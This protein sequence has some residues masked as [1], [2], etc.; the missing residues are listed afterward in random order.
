M[1]IDS[2]NIRL[3]T[4]NPDGSAEL[5]FADQSFSNIPK[6]KVDLKLQSPKA[7][8]KEYE[9]DPWKIS[10]DR[11]PQ[12]QVNIDRLIGHMKGEIQRMDD[13]LKDPKETLYEEHPHLLQ[14]VADN[15]DAYEG[16]LSMIQANSFK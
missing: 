1:Y 11:N 7:V 16:L 5:L 6:A 12:I 10:F 2:S 4:V 8:S 13:L 3:I 15:K 9:C 14:S